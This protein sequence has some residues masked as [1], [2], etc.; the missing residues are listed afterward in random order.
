[1]IP[2]RIHYCWFGDEPL[3]EIETKCLESWKKNLPDYE[4]IAWLKGDLD[5]RHPIWVHQAVEAQKYA[6]AGDYIRLYALYHYGGIYLDLD[7]EVL[8]S[9]DPFMHHKSFI[10]LDYIGDFEAAVIGSV[11]RLNWIRSVMRI[12][13]T[14]SFFINKDLLKYDTQPIPILIKKILGDSTGSENELSIYAQ[15]YF[16]PKNRFTGIIT[17]T[18]RTYT[19]H[20]FNGAWV[21]DTRLTRMKLLTHTIL[22]RFLPVSTHKK[23]IDYIRKWI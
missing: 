2:K 1:M 15:D 12:Y 11:P 10:G 6:F 7:V 4:I 20:H 14:K 9:L 8:R 22:N 3:G 13:E 16:S 5:S 17:T 21:D 19:I 18:N 23:I